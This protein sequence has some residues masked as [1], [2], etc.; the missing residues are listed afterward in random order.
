MSQICPA[1]LWISEDDASACE[2]CGEPFAGHRP[3]VATAGG[4]SRLAGNLAGLGAAALILTI[5]A[6]QAAL[7]WP[8]WS[9]SLLG[10]LRQ[11]GAWLRPTTFAQPILIGMFVITL[12]LWIVLW[13]M[14]RLG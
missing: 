11:A 10:G 2:R 5:A 8:H 14:A 1:C 3:P 6:R 7:R 4:L 12:I 13:L 9:E